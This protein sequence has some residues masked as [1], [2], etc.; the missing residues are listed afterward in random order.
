[1]LLQ[2]LF[3]QQKGYRVIILDSNLHHCT[4]LTPHRKTY[5]M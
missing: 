3:L 4:K 5:S 2:S 1:M